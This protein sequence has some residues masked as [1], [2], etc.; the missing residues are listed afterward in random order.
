VHGS[1][2][3]DGHDVRDI[4]CNSIRRHIG[5]VPQ[6]STLFNETLMYNLKYANQSATDEEVHRACRAAGI[7]DKIMAFPDGYNSK[8]GDLGLRLSGGEKQRV[9]IARAI[10]KDTRIILLDE[11]T[12]ALDTDSETHIQKSLKA[13][14]YDRTILV[15]AHRLSTIT[16]ADCILVLHEGRVVERG[17]HAELL[18][19]NGRY[20]HMWQNQTGKSAEPSS[21]ESDSC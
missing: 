2:Y 3:V 12:S 14:S 10:L 15:I 17:T 16:A 21:E 4:T 18:E 19:L 8:V 11:A 1:V 7:H 5:I 9:A 6:D 13:I 20:S